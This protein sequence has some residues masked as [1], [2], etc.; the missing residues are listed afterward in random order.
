MDRDL[1]FS[2][3]EELD[4]NGQT[5]YVLELLIT[6]INFEAQTKELTLYLEKELEPMSTT[7]QFYIECLKCEPELE[8]V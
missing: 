7:V 3:S 5:I 2:L 8:N 1:Y 6:D 4:D